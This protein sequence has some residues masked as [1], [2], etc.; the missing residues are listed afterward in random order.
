MVVLDI[1]NQLSEV[2]LILHDIL[3]FR[4]VYS[5]LQ[6]TACHI[7]ILLIAFVLEMYGNCRMTNSE[8]FE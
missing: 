8:P 6:V 7:D 1:D 2:Y 5:H 3:G 4:V